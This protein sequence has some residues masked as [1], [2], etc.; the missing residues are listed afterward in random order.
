MPMTK[1]DELAVAALRTN[2]DFM[3]RITVAVSG[4]IATVFKELNTTPNHE[5]RLRWAVRATRNTRGIAESLF[6]AVV[7]Y[8]SIRNNAQTPDVI[9][10]ANL[11]NAVGDVVAGLAEF[12]AITGK[13][14]DSVL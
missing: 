2:E 1:A 4:T 5:Y 9:T 6:W 13:D 14:M 12:A 7:G 8:G 10:E 3:T 11:S